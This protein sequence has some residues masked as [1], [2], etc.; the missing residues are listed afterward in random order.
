[1]KRIIS[2]FLCIT[3]LISVISVSAI[4]V[5]AEITVND[6][7]QIGDTIT[8]GK[9]LNEPIAWRCV[10]I[11]ENGPL[12][13]SEKILCLKAFDAR[14]ANDYYHSDGWGWVRRGS[15]SNCWSDSNLRQWLNS[16]ADVVGYTHCPPC[17]NDVDGGYNAYDNEPGFL[18]A[19]SDAELAL[20][21]T[22][23]QKSYINEWETHR[24]GYFDGGRYELNYSVSASELD[25]SQYFY[26]NVTDKIFLLNPGQVDATYRNLGESY[27]LDAYPTA[28]AIKKSNY[29]H[30]G[31][32][33]D[34]PWF[35]WLGIP[36][37]EGASYECQSVS[38]TFDDS[39][40]LSKALGAAGTWNGRVGVRPAFYL[41]IDIGGD[42]AKTD[43]G[44]N[45][46]MNTPSNTVSVGKTVELHVGYYLNNAV[47][48]NPSKRY[49]YTSSNSDS[50]KIVNNGWSNKRGQKL[51]ITGIREG[52]TAIT[53]TDPA[54][55]EHASIN[56]IVTPKESAWTFNSVPKMEIEAG[57]VTNFYNYS[58]MV[59]DDFSYEEHKDSSGTV[60][61]Y[62]VK[63][64]IYNT[65]NLYGAVTSYTAEGE[66]YGYWIID[67]KSTLDTSF[68]NSCKSL[69]YEGGDVFY[70]VLNK[71]Y[72]SGKSISK[73]TEV[74]EID[75]PVGGRLS[76]SNNVFVSD[77]AD[78]TN[79]CS[80]VLAASEFFG[81]FSKSENDNGNNDNNDIKNVVYKKVIDEI[82]EKKMLDSFD[83]AIIK[84]L[85]NYNLK[86]NNPIDFIKSVGDKLNELGENFTEVLEEKFLTELGLA[87]VIESVLKKTLPTG[88]LI[89][90]LY[91]FNKGCDMTVMFNQYCK[92]KNNPAGI[93]IYAPT[94]SGEFKSS[95]ISFT[96]DN[97]SDDT[98]IHAYTIADESEAIIGQKTFPKET[99]YY[100][101][102]Y[103]TYNITL[104]RNG[105]ETQPESSVTV[106]IPLPDG[107]RGMLTKV[108]RHNDDGTLTD[109]NARYDNGYMVFDT[110]H[111]SYYSVVDESDSVLSDELKF[112]G[113][114]LT[115]HDNLEIN[116]KAP[117]SLISDGYK[118]LY[119][120]F[121]STGEEKYATEYRVW[122]DKIVFD[123][124]DIAPNQ[125]GEKIV[126][127]L[128]AEKDGTI[129]RS[130]PKEYSVAEYCYN[131]LDKYSSEEYSDLRTLIVDLLNYG[132]EAQAYTDY[133][134]DS[135]VNGWLTEEQLQYG[136]KDAPLLQTVQDIAYKTIDNPAVD[137]R[138]AGLN[139]QKSVTM[140]FKIAAESIEGLF[141]QIKGESYTWTIGSDSFEETDGGYYVYFDGLNAGQMSEPV[142]LTV[143][144][145]NTAVSNTVCYSIE[146]YVYAKQSNSDALLN[147]LLIAMMKYGNS[148]YGY[149]KN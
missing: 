58:G 141:V 35:Y 101:E 70:L 110:N 122:N 108:Y 37:N 60:D 29:K 128:Y 13:L 1:M 43:N 133:N 49:I 85:K 39:I 119:V 7:I 31:L 20:I 32:S 71:S 116:Y 64:N 68:V 25:Y 129:Y 51:L 11:D 24:T 27:L 106:Q 22:V 12:M 15:G 118:H 145:G 87:S 6:D 82:L 36:R 139:L 16:A 80:L 17:A 28:S 8:L 104:Y 127:T 55:G 40:I 79:F 56:I 59:I 84:T 125:L 140:R 78:I 102:K 62:K 46:F 88:E 96:S 52:T 111:F 44:F 100:G 33:S 89:S 131:I 61:Y 4:N 69:Y 76:I 97:L 143:Y 18:N 120:K 135:P 113:A 65:K 93:E 112:A 66:I 121:E 94:Y 149:V 75:V 83:K 98:I 147:S 99:S 146:S 42:A 126:A 63:M 2:L 9:Y 77:I 90:M 34:K 148:A 138:G 136:T 109:M 5:N 73:K 41:N 81:D 45:F 132:T 144:D 130:A 114:S 53:V 48:V 21:K 38:G 19:F 14:G 123:Y 50:I 23:T 134:T 30:A 115:L 72:Y 67:K 54:T 74:K 47:T 137:W 105:M 95:G 10:D 57:K 92:S 124:S 91:S 117:S 107:Y 26:Q 3:L 103:Q 142:Y 86:D